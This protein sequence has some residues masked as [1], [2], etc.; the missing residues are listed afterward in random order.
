MIDPFENS[1]DR[2]ILLLNSD[3]IFQIGSKASRNGLSLAIHAIGDLANRTVLDAYERLRDFEKANHLKFLH[4]RIEHVQLL[5]PEDLNRLARL[6]ITASMQPIHATSD[7]HISDRYW[8]ERTRG[9]YAFRS[10][11]NQGTHMIFGSD[12]PVEIPDPF[13]GLHAA[14]TRRRKD[15]SPGDEGWHSEQRISLED[16]L[17]AYTSAPAYAAGLENRAG[18]LASGYYA[19]LIVLEKDPFDIPPQQLF[20]LKPSATMVGGK[21]VWQSN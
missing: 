1:Q 21:W 13:V 4:H 11:L 14:V 8:G 19:D 7:M 12:A 17:C 6:N 20:E 3:E 5:H 15:G 2:G 9:A 16:A 10:L 18:Q